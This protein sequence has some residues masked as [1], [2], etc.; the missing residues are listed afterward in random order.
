MPLSSTTHE[1]LAD[2]EDICLT[3]LDGENA[4]RV[5][6]QRKLL[7]ALGNLGRNSLAQQ[8]AILEK[9]RDQVEQVASAKYD[10]GDYCSYA[11]GCVVRVTTADWARYR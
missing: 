2:L 10:Q 6:V 4:V 8:L 11:N 5:E 1:G 3:M 9:H 7:A